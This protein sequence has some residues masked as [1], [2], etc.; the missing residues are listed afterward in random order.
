MF[1]DTTLRRA[2]LTA[3]LT[4]DEVVKRTR[5]SPR[6]VTLLDEGRFQDL[7]GGLYAR[8]YVR[9]FATAVAT[10]PDA[11][12]SR[13]EGL[14]P[15][16]ADPL[17]AL[18]GS[19]GHLDPEKRPVFADLQRVWESVAAKAKSSIA[20]TAIARSGIKPTP[21]PIVARRSGAAVFDT[22]L[23]ATINAL[24]LRTVASLC[25]FGVTA[26]V[27]A[28]GVAVATFCA[29]TMM[30]YYIFLAG[31]GGRTPGNWLCR[32]RPAAP[33]A[34]LGPAAILIRAWHAWLEQASVVVDVAMYA[35]PAPVK[36]L[37][38]RLD[39]IRHRAA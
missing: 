16:T 18:R 12:L 36:S 13:L 9:A 22:A 39:V 3:G 6:L 4:I 2:R 32:S 38:S 1:R 35:D 17:D 7:P 34:R 19:L 15:G 31:I 14:L 37:L 29:I 8:S 28:N 26:L 5:L 33:V 24:L 20:Q 27:E 25:G 23:I 10:D 21:L 11:A 30:L